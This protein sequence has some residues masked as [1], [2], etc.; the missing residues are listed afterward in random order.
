MSGR[1]AGAAAPLRLALDPLLPARTPPQHGMFEYGFQLRIP[2]GPRI[3]R[4]D[5]LLAAYGARIASVAVHEHD[6]EP[7][8]AATFDPGSVVA[9][10]P[11]V[12]DPSDPEVGVWD[13]DG[14]RRAG[15]LL[16]HAAR[17]VG[18][19]LEWG[20]EQSALVLTEDRSA[21][22]DRREGL[23]LLIFHPAF[24][25]VDTS[26]AARYERPVR[27]G[28]RRLVLVADG[29]ADVR[30]W[31]PAAQ[32]GP[33]A[34]EELPMSDELARA[35]GQLRSAYAELHEAGDGERRG[36]ERFEAELDRCALD[37]QAAALWRR[38]RAEL[39]RRFAIGFLG[40]GMQRPVWSP[41]QLEEDDDEEL[42]F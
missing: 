4:G 25:V 31:D 10:L 6:D 3:D 12:D 13:R 14:V 39:G 1:P 15:C 41:E 34:A 16:E 23:D 24:V 9:L 19:A 40:A 5:P 21:D 35:M 37:E 42:P 38:A 26:A 8:Q 33:I 11:D 7:L 32:T 27:P 22:E 28:R 30:W 36:F 17:V 18:A 2:D 29:S 20:L